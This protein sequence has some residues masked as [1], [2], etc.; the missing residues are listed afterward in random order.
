M[1]AL[2]RRNLILEKLQEEKKVVVS[3]LSQFYNVSEETIRRDLEKL[4]QD[5]VQS[6][7]I[8]GMG[9]ALVIR[10]LQPVKEKELGIQEWILQP[11]SELRKVRTY[12]QESGYQV[13]AENM[14]LDDGK[15]YPMMKVIKGK[16]ENV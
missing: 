4:E 8:A 10:I 11:Q 7:V 2:E 6:V 16:N 12:L 3:E 5:E 15:Y 14:V 1:L 9:G 13:V